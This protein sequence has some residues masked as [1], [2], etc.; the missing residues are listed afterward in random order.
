MSQSIRDIRVFV[1]AYEERSF[2]AAAAREHATQSGVSQ[3]IRKLEERFGTRLFART[4]GSVVPTAAGDVYYRSCLEVLR[5]Y[6]AS[7][8]TMR[9]FSGAADGE[10]VIGLMPTMTRCALAPAL[11]RFIALH[12]NVSVQV[13]E[14]Y[15]GVLTEQVRAGTLAFAV[16]PA[17]AGGAGLR[18]RLFARTREVLVARATD[19]REHLAPVRLADLPPMKLV[20]PKPQNSRRKTVETYITSNGVRVD[21]MIELDAMMGTLDFVATTDWVTVL[22]GVMM[23]SDVDPRRFTVNPLDEPPLW[24]DLVQIESAH[25]ALTPMAQAFSEILS[26]ETTRLNQPWSEQAAMAR[27]AAEAAPAKLKS[28]YGRR[29]R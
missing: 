25:H 24:L 29:R 13:V 20:L 11:E 18:Q 3:H 21:R 22:P 27:A 9:P 26:E 16:V 10:V 6:N 28:S 12:P 5:A 23:A 17:F 8:E 4:A 7:K 15:S 14:A 1:A 19:K 2:T